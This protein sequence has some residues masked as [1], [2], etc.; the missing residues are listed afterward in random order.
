MGGKAKKEIEGIQEYLKIRSKWTKEHFWK[1]N[2]LSLHFSQFTSKKF[3][4]KLLK[5]DNMK[6]FQKCEMTAQHSYPS[7]FP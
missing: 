7:P 2:L 5:S 1:A 3:L 4:K 6:H